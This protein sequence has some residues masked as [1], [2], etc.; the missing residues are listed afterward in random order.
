M[1]KVGEGKE[2]ERA[3]KRKEQSEKD[4]K[5]IEEMEI[6]LGSEKERK[7]TLEKVAVEVS[8]KEK[9]S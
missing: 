4:E 8:G 1:T 6:F 3:R 9:G 5:R 2:K 7:L